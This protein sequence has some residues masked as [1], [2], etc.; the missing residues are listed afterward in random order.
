MPMHVYADDFDDFIKAA[1]HI[2][3]L[4]GIVVTIPRKFS[5]FK[6]CDR[7]APRSKFIQVVNVLRRE[8]DGLWLG[9]N[10]DGQGFVSGMFKAGGNPK[11]Q[12]V[13]LIGAGGAGSAI[14]LELLQE[15]AVEL[16]IH[17]IVMERRDGLISRLN[18]LASGKCV[19]GSN[20]PTGFGVV[21]NATPLG[22]KYKDPFPIQIDRLEPY[23][24]VG[25]VVT[26][27]LK[28]LLIEEALK[29][30]CRTLSGTG[31]FESQ[32]DILV[33]FLIGNGTK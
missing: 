20:D 9:D 3:N 22:M 12:K 27:P 1:K 26:S 25:D 30:G 21:I 32:I 16:A 28:P 5:A 29:K 33:D 7:T 2:Q 31:M 11:G 8:K 10:T 4:D 6:H 23:A 17:D 15:G 13:L 14:A 19:I 18:A 24:F